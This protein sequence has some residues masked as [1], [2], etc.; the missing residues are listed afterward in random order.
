MAKQLG[1]ARCHRLER[2]VLIRPRVEPTS[3]KRSLVLRG[4]ASTAARNARGRIGRRPDGELVPM[5]F[6]QEQIWLHS[7]LAP[8][9]PLYTESL[10]IRRNGFLDRDALVAAFREIV[11]RHDIWRTTFVWSCGQIVQHVHGDI[12]PRIRVADLRQLPEDEREVSALQLAAADLREPFDLSREPGVRAH[13]VTLSDR[14]H[15]LYLCLHHMVF[16]GISI[17]R[18]VLPELAA[19]Y[20]ANVRGTSGAL[21][22]PPLQYADYAYWQR[23]SV[24]ETAYALHARYWREQLAGAP[25]M[26]DLPADHARPRV[27]SF[28]GTVMRFEF[29]RDLTAAARSASRRENCTLFMLLLAS[30]GVALHRWTRQTDMVIGTVSGGR[31]EPELQHLVGYFLRVLPLRNDLSGNPTFREI[32]SRVRGVLI[33]ALCHEILP[34]QRLVQAVGAERDLGRSPL[35]Q[36]TFSIEPPMPDVGA[37]WD[38]TEMDAGTSVSKFDLSIELEDRGE[39][40]TGRAIYSLDLFDASTVFEFLSDWAALLRRAVADPQQPL[41]DLIALS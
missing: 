30:F 21:E 10:T 39:V 20:E 2:D 16:D 32:V 5:T 13:L 6:G 28:R 33:E 27:Q 18:V 4:P 31:D 11:R 3:V 9:V 38:L 15:R 36:V 14:D 40:V 17:Y 8:D 29:P 23:R 25:S 12:E 41:Q 22:E 19:A 34:F 1:V 24:D 35:F 26:I 37:E 7:Q